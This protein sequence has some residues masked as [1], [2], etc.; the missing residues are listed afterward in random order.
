MIKGISTPLQLSVISSFGYTL[1]FPLVIKLIRIVSRAARAFEKLQRKDKG[2][3]GKENNGPGAR[4]DATSSSSWPPSCSSSEQRNG[5][6]R[7]DD[8]IISQF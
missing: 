4:S 3:V 7:A 1:L 5:T 6:L 8:R 2:R